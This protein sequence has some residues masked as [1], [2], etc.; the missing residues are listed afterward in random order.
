MGLRWPM[1]S[2]C[3]WAPCKSRSFTSVQM[4]HH[5]HTEACT[6]RNLHR[7]PFTWKVFTHRSFYTQTLLHRE[8][9]T[10]RSF[11]TRRSFTQRSFYTQ[12]LL[13]TEKLLHTEAFCT[14]NFCTVKSLH[15]GSFY[16]D[17]SAH[18]GAFTQR[19]LCTEGHLHT[20]AFTHKSFYTEQGGFYTQKLLHT[21][22]FTERSLSTGKL[23][24][25]KVFTQRNPRHRML[26][27]PSVASVMTF[28]HHF[29]RKGCSWAFQNCNV[30]PVFW[31]SALICAVAHKLHTISAEGAIPIPTLWKL[32]F[33]LTLRVRHAQDFHRG[34]PFANRLFTAPAA[35]RKN[36]EE[37]E[38]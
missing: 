24:H 26:Q 38:K 23:L 3:P 27:Y 6:Q 22:A 29:V 9:F 7:D 21:K 10:R 5:T 1:P 2:K 34:S 25:T 14:E 36:L 18:T 15:R 32:A 16:T 11:Y 13:P 20:D 4:L 35:L 37:L 19:S 30:L 28:D 31:P 17:K 8:V 33:H 12:K